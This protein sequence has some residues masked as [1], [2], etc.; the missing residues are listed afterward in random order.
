MNTMKTSLWVAGCVVASAV[1]WAPLASA[2]PS[3]SSPEMKTA[4]AKAAQG[5][6]SLRRYVERTKPIYMLDYNEV[7]SLAYPERL[8]ATES[9]PKL[10]ENIRR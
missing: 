8:S 10:A 4:F 1:A 7:M 2:A 3:L 9:Q 6:E 5:P